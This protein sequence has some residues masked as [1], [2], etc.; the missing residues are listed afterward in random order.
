MSKQK[1]TLDK[2]VGRG[3]FSGFESWLEKFLVPKVPRGL[4]TYHLT[5]MTILWSLLIILGGYL[6]R[7]SINWLWF[8]SVMIFLQYI[9]DFVDGKVGKLRKTGL[10]KWGYYMDHFLD[11]IFLS[12]I[13]ISYAFLLRGEM[14][15][16][17][18]ITLAIY[19][20]FMVNSYLSFSATNEFKIHYLKIGPTEVR[21]VFI[22]I[23][24]LII[25]F[26]KTYIVQVLPYV[27]AFSILGLIVVV[28]RTQRKIWK[29]DEKI[30]GEKIG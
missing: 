4:E 12:S 19:G 30:K 8:V 6:T 26:G 13:L 7:F 23:N 5:N 2:K 3:L 22:I 10:I 17:L 16:T 28:Y 25:I 18:L 24:T 29:L 1:T 11:Y 15:Y 21:L 20:S 14:H 27:F 9:T